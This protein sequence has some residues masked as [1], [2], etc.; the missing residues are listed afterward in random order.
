[1]ECL[2]YCLRTKVRPGFYTD[3]T[4]WT[5]R[6]TLGVLYAAMST[7][8]LARR[9]FR[10]YVLSYQKE[11]D[12]AAL[13]HASGIDVPPGT[14]KGQIGSILAAVPWQRDVPAAVHIA[15][16]LQIPADLLPLHAEKDERGTVCG[17]AT[18]PF[19]P[20]KL[21]QLDV[22][23]RASSELDSPFSRVLIQMPTGSGKTRTAMEIISRF[24]N[25][26]TGPTRVLWLAHVRELCEQAQDAFVEVWE[27][28]G[29]QEVAVNLIEGSGDMPA[30]LPPRVFVAGGLQKLYSQLKKTRTLPQFDLVVIDEAHK[31]VAPTY[32]QVIERT[33]GWGGR[34]LGLTA[35]PGRLLGGTREN[36]RMAA[37][38]NNKLVGLDAQ[39]IGERDEDMG[40][41]R[42]LQ[43]GRIL[44]RLIREPI[45]TGLNIRLTAADLKAIGA[46][47]DYSED[48]LRC[49]ASDRKR[50]AVIISKLIEV[51]ERGLRTI[52]FGTSVEQSKIMTALLVAK[53][54]PAAHVDGTTPR[55]LRAA[56][57]AR[58]KDGKIKVLLN[59]DV[60]STGF[61]APKTD[62]VFI[63]RP[64]QS[65][66]LYS[67]MIGRGLRGPSIGGKETCV[68][69]DVVDNLETFSPDLDD[70]YG[71]FDEYWTGAS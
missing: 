26:R 31:A 37:F 66:V 32:E 11:E 52:Y 48:L 54:I 14:P 44:A 34:L 59:F 28:M 64:T 47:G 7:D 23:D 1:M 6:A 61:D 41:M 71:F 13:V 2:D 40:V 70:I 55:A 21:Y 39:L 62:A 57:A 69:I 63:A 45:E 65:V 5:D 33:V 68:L 16:F 30:D 10:Q 49:I 56:H 24:L 20:L 38:F 42:A 15:Q 36:A 67:Q 29:E 12:L 25:E 9:E 58:F 46:R 18:R 22:A 8:R 43:R 35:T 3:E 50:N 19:K 17:P 4:L 51:A 27:H 53:G 60:F